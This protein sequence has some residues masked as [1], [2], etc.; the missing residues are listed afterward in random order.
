M[1]RSGVVMTDVEFTLFDTPIGWCGLAWGRRGV[2]G[3][4]LPE[5]GDRATR[6]HLTERFPDAREAR[7]PAAI[8]RVRDAIV[9]LL[10]GE[11]RDLSA[12]A[13]DMA[14]LPPFHRR[15]YRAARKIPRG[16]TLSYGELAARAGARRA[17]RAVGQ[18]MRRNPFPIVVP[19]HRVLASGG[20]LGGYSGS[21]GLSTKLALL[22]L[23]G[24]TPARK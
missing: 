1:V 18:A 13:L 24:A 7:P 21:G 3:V 17:A 2:V 16:A 9:A 23:E 14:G 5:G 12:V 15:V 19:C 22:T 4:Q 10:R 11:A 20:R 6:A 8:Q